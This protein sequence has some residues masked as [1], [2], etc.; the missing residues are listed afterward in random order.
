MANQNFAS[1]TITQPFLGA[2]LQ[3]QP[4]LGSQELEQLIDAFVT[5]SAS[6]KDKLSEVT[7]D[8]YNH[9]TVDL[10]TG[11]LVR[12]YDVAI[13][14]P[15]EQSPT[16]TQ[17]SGFSPPIYTPSP[18]S[19]TFADSAYGSLSMTPPSR[20]R[21]ATSARVSK[22]PKKETKKAAEVRLPGFSIMTK[23]GID[24]TSTAGRGT[25]T[26]EQ[27]E[28]AHL[29][30]IMKACNDCKRKKIRCDPSHRRSSD[31][32]TRTSTSTSSSSRQNPSPTVS[33]PSLSHESTYNSQDSLPSVG[34]NAIDDF[35]LFPEDSASWSPADMSIP[36]FDQGTELSQFNFDMND[37]DL[38]NDFST[39]NTDQYLD[40]STYDQPSGVQ[41]NYN[42]IVTDQYGLDQWASSYGGENPIS[43][44]R[45]HP[46]ASSQDSGQL[47]SSWYSDSLQ[48]D[49]STC[50]HDRVLQGGSLST[51]PTDSSFDLSSDGMKLSDSPYGHDRVLQ[52]GSSRTSSTSASSGLS[53]HSLSSANVSNLLT[54]ENQD[55]SDLGLSNSPSEGSGQ[56]LSP[57]SPM[58]SSDLESMYAEVQESLHI[59]QAS[60]ARHQ[61]L[62]REL[63]QIRQ[64]ID[65]VKSGPTDFTT[66][67][68]SASVMSQLRDLTLQLQ[69]LAVNT[70][71]TLGT[72]GALPPQGYNVEETSLPRERYIRQCQ[73]SARRLVRSL[74]AT[75][76]SLQVPGSTSSSP[77]S[78]TGVLTSGRNLQL[79][80]SPADRHNRDSQTAGI[81][82]QGST[83]SS[84]DNSIC[85]TSSSYS[86]SSRNSGIMRE[87]DGLNGLN[88]FSVAEALESAHD[89]GYHEPGSY[90]PGQN[91]ISAT[92]KSPRY[93]MLKETISPT[94]NMQESLTHHER[95]S[96]LSSG[97]FGHSSGEG[98]RYAALTG[99]SEEARVI[100][101]DHTPFPA[102][103]PSQQLLSQSSSVFSE[104]T[105]QQLSAPSIQI[106][107]ARSGGSSRSASIAQD[108]ASSRGAI[109]R[110]VLEQHD[111]SLA[112]DGLQQAPQLLATGLDVKY[113]MLVALALSASLAILNNLQVAT[114]G[115]MNMFML[116]AIPL[117][118]LAVAF[119]RQSPLATPSVSAS[120]VAGL[121]LAL[122]T[123]SSL[124]GIDHVRELCTRWSS[125]DSL[126][127]MAKLLLCCTIVA[128]SPSALWKKM[129]CLRVFAPLAVAT[130]LVNFSPKASGV[131]SS[132]PTS[133]AKNLQGKEISGLFEIL[134]DTVRVV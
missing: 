92:R 124:P 52:G 123:L 54:H 103:A 109:P 40:F 61:S 28:H 47:I 119:H 14:F 81:Q 72:A 48:L 94:T 110:T 34:T 66:A 99:F 101:T 4:A 8:F 102:S 1:F 44:T 13:P 100:R 85:V 68:V 46:S 96:D 15:F 57:A 59:L 37:L 107:L 31:T 108:G 36:G 23:D 80:V 91:A 12:R 64:S 58:Y 78:S 2:P 75:I 11:A 17:S 90:G 118:L 53:P 62:S 10:N 21:G 79:L 122:F 18:A 87:I 30:R 120:L 114:V 24:V 19:T 121:A 77:T 29:M 6:K 43:H 105:L 51:S 65:T 69:V 70:T 104:D 42:P 76:C 25:K 97:S 71:R 63:F 27:R 112:V 38:L 125:N 133:F 3:F 49:N 131:V 22:K 26:K 106:M 33:V 20:N 74:C 35:V 32:M 88:G 50:G 73:V 93:F 89:L 7:I 55:L 126:A 5:G 113:S 56:T 60:P 83:D 116:Y 9:A 130:S 95:L 111:T 67:L 115:I 128:Q 129:D 45:P 82:L 132:T 84:F 41:T 16:L 98:N 39:V 127:R 86:S 134:S 117:C